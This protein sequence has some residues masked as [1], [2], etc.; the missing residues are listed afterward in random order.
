MNRQAVRST[1]LRSV[2]YDPAR[3]ILEVE[4]VNGSIYQY[5]S[6]PEHEYRGLMQASSHG[7]Y[8]DHHIKKGPYSYAKIR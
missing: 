4:F 2:G 8:F 1:N 7:S 6:V 3:R 5:Y